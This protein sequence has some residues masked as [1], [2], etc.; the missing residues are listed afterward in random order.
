M[1]DTAR[2]RRHYHNGLLGS[3]A[4][5]KRTM[6]SIGTSETTT[7]KAKKIADSISSLL[8]ELQEEVYNFRVEPNGKIVQVCHDWHLTAE[9]KAFMAEIEAE[10]Q[11]D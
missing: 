9:Q 3:L 1:V 7:S 6:Y 10:R 4:M 2:M 5:A 8:C 11:F